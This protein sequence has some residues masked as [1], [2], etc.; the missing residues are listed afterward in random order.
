[1]GHRHDQRDF[2]VTF[3][4]QRLEISVHIV[5]TVG[6]LLLWRSQSFLLA[7]PS[8]KNYRQSTF[9]LPVRDQN[10]GPSVGP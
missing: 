2:A 9:L 7:F 4:L 8:I 1:M 3:Y 6:D 5:H 10:R